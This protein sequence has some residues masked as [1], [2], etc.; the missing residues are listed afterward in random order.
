M[1]VEAKLLRLDD[2]RRLHLLKVA[3]KMHEIGCLKYMDV[4]DP[5]EPSNTEKSSHRRVLRLSTRRKLM[6]DCILCAKYEHCFMVHCTK[7]WNI[8]REDLKLIT[9]ESF[10]LASKKKWCVIII[11]WTS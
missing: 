8:L 3:Y 10:V 1:H 7:L 11:K 6:F 5:A 4:H 2:R 9:L